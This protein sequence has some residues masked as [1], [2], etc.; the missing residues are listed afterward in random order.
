MLYF[1]TLFY[2]SVLLVNALAVLSEERFLARIGWDS[3]QA[4]AQTAA[5]NQPYAQGYD[6]TGYGRQQDASVKTRIINL[7]SAVRT[8]MRSTSLSCVKAIYS[9]RTNPPVVPLIGLNLIIIVYEMIS[10]R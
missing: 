6:Q 2:V 10:G 8:L 9:K 5:Y 3:T 7:I 4:Q 1:G